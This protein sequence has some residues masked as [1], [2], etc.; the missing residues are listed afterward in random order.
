MCWWRQIFAQGILW[1]EWWSINI[2]CETNIYFIWGKS[3]LYTYIK[4]FILINAYN[5]RQ[6]RSFNYTM[7]TYFMSLDR[8]VNSLM[9]HLMLS[10]QFCLIINGEK[11]SCY[12]CFIHWVFFHIKPSTLGLQLKHL[13]KCP[14]ASF[15]ESWKVHVWKSSGCTTCVLFPTG[16]DSRKSNAYLMTHGRL[17]F[18]IFMNIEADKSVTKIH[19][20]LTIYSLLPQ[21]FCNLM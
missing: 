9:K 20:L 13:Y 7:D 1:N 15:H 14:E 10:S 17:A 12:G 21:Y 2:V 11:L 8:L 5:L 3:L 6:N 16:Q 4:R 18:K 19:E